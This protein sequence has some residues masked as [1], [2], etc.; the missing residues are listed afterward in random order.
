MSYIYLDRYAKY[1]IHKIKICKIFIDNAKYNLIYQKK[2]KNN[3]FY[4]EINIK[5]YL[6]INIQM[7]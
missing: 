2:N 4:Y 6:T 3:F 5:N 1:T 7:Y